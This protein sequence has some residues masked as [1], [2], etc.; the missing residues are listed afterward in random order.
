LSARPT[1]KMARRVEWAAHLRKS[2][3]LHL[4]PD[5]GQRCMKFARTPHAPE[6]KKGV[7]TIV[8]LLVAGVIDIKDQRPRR[9][10][11][12]FA[13]RHDYTGKVCRHFDS[14][15][16]LISPPEWFF[17]RLAVAPAWLAVPEGTPWLWTLAYGYH[18]DRTPIHDYEAMR[19]A[20]RHL[21]N[22]LQ[23]NTE[24]TERPSHHVHDSLIAATAPAQT[25][26]AAIVREGNWHKLSYGH[27]LSHG[28]RRMATQAAER[29]RDVAHLIDKRVLI[30]KGS[31]PYQSSR[32][33]R[34]SLF[35]CRERIIAIRS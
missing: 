23:H 14:Q 20:A 8:K 3:R 21:T 1:P 13:L 17:L 26:N 30:R 29:R 19:E 28:A 32:Q 22:W 7:L 27:N 11:E 35:H 24:L 16:Q 2:Q 15:P 12:M 4:L 31:F 25:I 6:R 10:D 33:Y 18:E 34:Y 5:T 9:D